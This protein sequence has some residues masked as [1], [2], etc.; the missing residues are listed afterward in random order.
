MKTV[1]SKLLRGVVFHFQSEHEGF[2]GIATG[3]WQKTGPRTYRPV[4]GPRGA[5][6]L[7]FR[8]GTI[9]VAVCTCATP[10][11]KES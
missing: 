8:V 4:R 6:P 11:V 5:S 2:T 9:K 7:T 10:H 1:F 3:P